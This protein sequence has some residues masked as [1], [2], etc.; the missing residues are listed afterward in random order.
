MSKYLVRTFVDGIELTD[1]QQTVSEA[2]ELVD[3][4]YVI[5]NKTATLAENGG[6]VFTGGTDGQITGESHNDA[7]NLL[8]QYSFDTFCVE[9]TDEELQNVYA[10]W[11]ERLRDEFGIKFQTVIPFT[12][13]KEGKQNF[14]YEGVIQVGTKN[15]DPNYSESSLVYWFAGA[16]AGCELQNSVMAQ[17]YEGILTPDLTLSLD[18]LDAYSENGIMVL[19]RDGDDIVV[20]EDINTLTEV[21]AEQ[22]E[23]KDEQ[24]KL[25]QTMRV[26]DKTAMNDATTF[27]KFYLG[28]RA[29][30]EVNRIDLRN[31]LLRFREE[32]LNIG[33]IHDSY[34]PSNLIILE[35][36]RV[37][38]VRGYDQLR[39]IS[40]MKAFD[41][42]VAVVNG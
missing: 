11:T 14:N 4:D 28:K 13:N 33:A 6:D 40:A 26:L 10:K 19:H 2:S 42:E 23:E 32:L 1:L 22:I 39:P 27:N 18:E 3:N 15:L 35:G 8:E 36:D 7:R 21:P 31:T 30:N 37:E 9:T 12:E 5:F 29:N 34:D 24:F 17:K 38:D 25:N 16:E 20:F 41:F